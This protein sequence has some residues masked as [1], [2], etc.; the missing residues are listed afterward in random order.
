MWWF[1]T[2]IIERH[3]IC[4]GLI[5]GQIIESKPLRRYPQLFDKYRCDAVYEWSIDSIDY[6][7][8]PLSFTIRVN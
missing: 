5:E 1:A 4:V 2:S 7:G 6:D 8:K 3:R